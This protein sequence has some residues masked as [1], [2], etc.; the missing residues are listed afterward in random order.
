MSRRG[1]RRRVVIASSLRSCKS[2]RSCEDTQDK[3]AKRALRIDRETVNNGRCQT[4]ARNLAQEKPD[5]RRS[6]YITFPIRRR[7]ASVYT[8][9]R[10]RFHSWHGR[11]GRGR[12]RNR[13]YAAA[14]SFHAWREGEKLRLFSL[15]PP[16]REFNWR[17]S[18]EISG[19]RIHSC[20][21]TR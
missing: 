12:R 21:C 4:I 19:V 3:S 8:S 20:G 6:S 17:D 1:G 15:P 10:G 16:L 14:R 7:S 9:R 2:A 18:G 13:G 11:E 5:C